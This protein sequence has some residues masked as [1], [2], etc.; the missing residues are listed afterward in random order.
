M[1]Y[2]K[3]LLPAGDPIKQLPNRRDGNGPPPKDKHR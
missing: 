3:I 1:T 2:K